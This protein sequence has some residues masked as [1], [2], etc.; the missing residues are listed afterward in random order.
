[1]GASSKHKAGRHFLSPLEGCISARL[2]RLLSG[3]ARFPGRQLR[4]APEVAIRACVESFPFLLQGVKTPQ[5]VQGRWRGCR[6]ACCS[7]KSAHHRRS[8]RLLLEEG[9]GALVRA[10]V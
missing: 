5:G 7:P 6:A 4:T 2:L 3:S 10:E 9:G 1:M 8:G